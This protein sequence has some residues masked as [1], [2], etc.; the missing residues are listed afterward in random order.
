MPRSGSGRCLRPS[1][2]TLKKLP[3]LSILL[4][5]A[6]CNDA[7]APADEPAAADTAAEEAAAGD[8]A[9]LVPEDA[10]TAE[11]TPL[12]IEG[13]GE[14]D[15]PTEEEAVAEARAAVTD[16]LPAA[17]YTYGDRT[18]VLSADGSYVDG[19]DKGWMRAVDN[20]ACFEANDGPQCYSATKKADGLFNLLHVVGSR[21][22]DLKPS[23]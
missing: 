15:T 12:N 8:E 14:A 19:S 1:G 22:F 9:S 16:I 11:E 20:N 17:T 5:T 21:N 7:S 3:I 4:A 23:T 2:K 13:T 6:A 10:T 18:L